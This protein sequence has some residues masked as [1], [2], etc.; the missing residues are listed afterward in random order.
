MAVITISNTGGNWNSTAT[1]VGGAIPTLV[2]SIAATATSGQ[3]TVNVNAQILSFDFTNYVNTLTIN[4]NITLSTVSSATSTISSGMSFN[5]LGSGASQGRIAKGAGAQTYIQNGTT[6]I[7][8]FA[9]T[10]TGG[11]LTL[12]SNLHIT[13]YRPTSSNAINGNTVFV[14]GDL[15]AGFS[16]IYGT[17]I[18][19]FVGTGTIQ[20]LVTG[21][22]NQN[23][24]FIIDCSGGTAT[25]GSSGFGIGNATSTSNIT[26][27]HLS[28]TIVNPTFRP[29]FNNGTHT[30]DLISG[31][32]WDLYG[33][34]SIGVSP[35]LTFTG[36][37]LFDKFI[38]SDT[39]GQFGF[40]YTLGGSQITTN[41]FAIISS[42][43]NQ[44]G[45]Y[46]TGGRSV[47][48]NTTFGGIIVNSSI[49]INGG[50]NEPNP[51]QTPNTVI[52]SGTPGT[53][54][55]LTINTYNQYVSLT[56][57]TDI[58]CSSGNTLY[59]QSLTL[60]NTTNITQYTLPPTTSGGGGSFTFVN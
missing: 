21:V 12:G 49:T 23:C 4:S 50:P 30:F 1:W 19:R 28:G 48:F 18:F 24:E 35:T 3:L 33:I 38:L 52:R 43:A 17:T 8:H 45:T 40:T 57:F 42:L 9:Q 46:Y 25:I 13:N 54:V 56:R 34:T 37:C 39:G 32:T 6:Q 47:I 31:T 29:N 2:D 15:N 59:G 41:D 20:V 16:S 27:R 10:S 36:T 58:N 11:A 14:Y 60:S 22:V 53:P 51:V 5:F 55:P 26:F 44:G 7:P